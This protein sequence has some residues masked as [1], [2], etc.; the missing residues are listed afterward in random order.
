M[1]YPFVPAKWDYGPRAGPALGL[2]YHMAEGG[3]TVHYLSKTGGVLRGVSVHAVCELS[4]RVVQ[5]LPWSHI[6]G[7]LNPADRSSD[8]L[9]FGHQ[10]LVDVLGPKWTDPNTV[11]LSMEIEGFAN[12]GP[13]H[14]QVDAAVAWGEDM[15]SLFS[16]L[17][18]ALGH[19]DQTDTKRCPGTTLAMRLIF[20]GVGGHG[21]WHPSSDPNQPGDDMLKV[22]DETEVL[23]DLVLNT[24]VLD[25]AGKHMTVITAGAVAKDVVSPFESTLGPNAT[26]RAAY[27]TSGGVRQ[28]G[29]IHKPDANVHPILTP[30]CKDKVAAEHERVRL[31]AIKAAEAL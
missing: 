18:G 3:G 7:S 8:K 22:S 28:L 9:Y 14:A 5:M 10:H 2:M 29:L 31:A 16:S 24:E 25:P 26:Y 30:D 1:T 13:N 27:V 12:L 6:S 19:A 21:L 4:G 20:E 23:I 15:K 17:R 11:V